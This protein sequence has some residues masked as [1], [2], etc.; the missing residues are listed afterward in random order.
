MNKYRIFSHIQTQDVSVCAY[1]S[2]GC[3][4]RRDCKERERELTEAESG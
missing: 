4:G 1:L 3:E 2:V